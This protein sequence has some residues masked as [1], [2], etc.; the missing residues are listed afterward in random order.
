MPISKFDASDDGR[1]EWGPGHLVNRFTNAKEGYL[2]FIFFNLVLILGI[3][4][5]VAGMVTAL[6]LFHPVAVAPTTTT[7][8]PAAQAFSQLP[9]EKWTLQNQFNLTETAW[10]V[11]AATA[12]HKTLILFHGR[13]TDHR[14]LATYGVHFH[15]LGYNVLLPDNLA[16]G[17]SQGGYTSAG[18]F[19]QRSACGWI[20][21]LIAADSQVAIGLFGT[22]VGAAIVGLTSDAALPTNV[23]LGVL[24]NGYTTA[25]VQVR[26]RLAHRHIPG[27]TT[28]VSLATQFL[29]GF[30]LERINPLAHVKRSRLP[31]L[32]IEAPTGDDTMTA[33]LYAAKPGHK[34]RL[35]LPH[36][37]V[38]ADVRQFLAHYQL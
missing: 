10:Y 25:Y 35:T 6:H 31:L 4:W 11:P 33:Q 36:N 30:A 16:T 14:A 24:A 23:K 9:A 17:A 5:L 19:E 15:Q 26:Q 8:D 13:Q 32:F 1:S 28:A 27:L 18:Y 3:L 21:Q 12:T 7:V 22:D 38:T 34:A 2:M 29:Y 37:Q 20:D